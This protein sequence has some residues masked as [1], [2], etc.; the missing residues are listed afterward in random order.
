MEPSNRRDP[1]TIGNPFG[2]RGVGQIQAFVVI[3]SPPPRMVRKGDDSLVVRMSLARGSQLTQQN[4]WKRMEKCRLGRVYARPRILARPDRETPAREFCL[5]GFST[6]SRWTRQHPTSRHLAEVD[7]AGNRLV[8]ENVS[9]SGPLECSIR[10]HVEGVWL[11]VE[12]MK[13]EDPEVDLN[14]PLHKL[15]AETAPTVGFVHDVKV[16]ERLISEHDSV[17]RAEPHCMM[18]EF[19]ENGVALPV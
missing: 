6:K 3:R 15:G 4:G 7:G 11:A 8:T 12:A 5:R 10:C 16:H 13:V 1:V 17:Q 9:E 19:P 2:A 14:G 18:I